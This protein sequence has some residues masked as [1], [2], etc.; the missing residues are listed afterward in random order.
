METRRKKVRDKED[1]YKEVIQDGKGMRARQGSGEQVLGR[2]V[3]IG[4]E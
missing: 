2:S 3:R 4:Y 1:R